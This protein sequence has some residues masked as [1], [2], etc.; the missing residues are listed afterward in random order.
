MCDLSRDDVRTRHYTGA[1]GFIYPYFDIYWIAV[2]LAAARVGWGIVSELT[3]DA[4]AVT[5]AAR[6]QTTIDALSHWLW[7]S[8]CQP[9]FSCQRRRLT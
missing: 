9:I 3:Q 7:N 5:S 8:A 6:Y 1:S 4:P 2:A